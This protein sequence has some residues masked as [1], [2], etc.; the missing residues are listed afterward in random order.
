LELAGTKALLVH[1]EDSSK[2]KKAE[3]TGVSGPI[4]KE[5]EKMKSP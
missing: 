2:R 4:F 1:Q 3:R 5:K